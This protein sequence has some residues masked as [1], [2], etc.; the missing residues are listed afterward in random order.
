MLAP[1]LIIYVLVAQQSI[2]GRFVLDQQLLML[3]LQLRMFVPY[4]ISNVRPITLRIRP[5]KFHSQR[6]ILDL[7]IRSGNPV[8]FLLCVTIPPFAICSHRV[9]TILR[10]FRVRHSLGFL[11]WNA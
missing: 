9:V 4:I 11:L 8:K 7:P 5:T 2:A 10:H 6:V 3:I 1:S